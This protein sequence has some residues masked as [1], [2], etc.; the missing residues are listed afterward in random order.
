MA[1]GFHRRAP[2]RRSWAISLALAT[3]LLVAAG[4]TNARAQTFDLPGAAT[5]PT[6]PPRDG[7]DLKA[8]YWQQGRVRPFIAA[9]FDLGGFFARSELQAGYGRPHNEWIG[10]FVNSRLTLGGVTMATGILGQVPNLDARITGRSF[11]STDQ[12][13]LRRKDLYYGS[14]PTIQTEPTVAYQTL[15][16]DLAVTVKAL[17]GTVGL[18]LRGLAL[19]NVAEGY[20][21]FEDTLRAVVRPPFA[22]QTRFTYLA[23]PGWQENLAVGFVAELIGAPNRDNLVFRTGPVVTVS[24]TDHLQAIGAAA[25]AIIYHD[26]LGLSGSDLG[27][28]ALR[29]RWASG[30]A[31]PN[32]P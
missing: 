9:V 1:R 4:A 28:I 8:P 30:E 14:D 3:S 21:V 16:A 11:R 18:E 19:F 17:G 24:L 2:A 23:W 25:F 20:D 6:A 10:G 27:Q 13:F 29:Y 5:N 31:W 22:W 12:H 7:V 26:E 15:E 32:F